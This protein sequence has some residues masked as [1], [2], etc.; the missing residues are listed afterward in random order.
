VQAGLL[1]GAPEGAAGGVDEYAATGGGEGG[2][3]SDGAAGGGVRA[4][5]V[6]DPWLSERQ[7]RALLDI[8][9]VFRNEGSKADTPD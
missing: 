3:S 1:D 9:E 4:A 2:E 7:K 8:Y 5:V 6:A